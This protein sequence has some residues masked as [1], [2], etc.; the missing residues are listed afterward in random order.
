MIHLIYVSC[1]T[2]EMSE[3]DLIALLQQC[4]SHNKNNQVTGMLLYADGNYFQILEGNTENV[5]ETYQ[6][7][8]NDDRNSGHILL[9]K[10][11]INERTFPEWSMGFKHLTK[12]QAHDLTGY[13]QFLDTS[14][15]HSISTPQSSDVATLLN[16]FKNSY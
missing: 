2:N 12:E 6:R 4:R 15:S 11:E 13:T 1:A 3:A 9:E 14:E 8:L 10:E 16:I 7:I 5:E